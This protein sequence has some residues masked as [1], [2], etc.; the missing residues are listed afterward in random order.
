VDHT[1][2]PIPF[3]PP[4][5]RGL[6]EA[7][8]AHRYEI[9]YGRAVRRLNAVGR[10]LA[11]GETSATKA[12]RL[13]AR[14]RELAAATRDVVLHEVSLDSLGGEDGLGSPAVPA[15]GALADAIHRDFGSIDLW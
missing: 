11:A 8:T 15:D 7:L 14:H 2:I 13:R 1:V 10:R 3:K 9:A 6:S 5:L 12:G 4:R